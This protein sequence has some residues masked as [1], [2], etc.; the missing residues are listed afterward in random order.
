M[1]AA[2][3]NG[4]GAVYVG[5]LRNQPVPVARELGLPPRVFPVFGLALGY[6]D[7]ARPADIKPRLPQSLVL[8]RE[9]YA[10]QLPDAGLAAYDDIL[11]A[12]N[13]S[14][15]LPPARWSERSLQRLRSAQ[16]LRGRDRIREAA[17]EL[18]FPL[19]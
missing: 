9:Q 7:P 16:D 2:E 5:A 17:A 1:T 19:R 10:Q 4:L 14:Q 18:G 12:F 8:H 3:A 6:P 13:R 11:A 15:N